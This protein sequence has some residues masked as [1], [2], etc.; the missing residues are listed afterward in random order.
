MEK[1]IKGKIYYTEKSQLITNCGIHNLELNLDELSEL[2]YKTKNGEYFLYSYVC[3]I[4]NGEN[5]L[6]EDLKIVDIF[7]IMKWYEKRQKHFDENE[8]KK[9][10]KEFGRFF[11]EA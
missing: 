10:F 3:N 11:I 9:F 2:L 5:K 1:I 4:I 6:G 7:E 8:K